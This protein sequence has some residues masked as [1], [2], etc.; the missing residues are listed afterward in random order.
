MP[1]HA[2]TYLLAGSKGGLATF[3]FY[4]KIWIQINF[5]SQPFQKFYLSFSLVRLLE[6]NFRLKIKPHD[7]QTEQHSLRTV[8][9]MAEQRLDLLPSHVSYWPSVYCCKPPALICIHL[10]GQIVS[11]CVVCGIAV[12]P[13]IW[14]TLIETICCSRHMSMSKW[15]KNGW[16]NDRWWLNDNGDGWTDTIVLRGQ[17]VSKFK[18]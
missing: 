4:M 12:L 8:T 17:N 5:E 11:T 1:V 9:V 14:L 16:M 7:K 6:L 2:L 10:G 18:H 3:G 13:L 15:V